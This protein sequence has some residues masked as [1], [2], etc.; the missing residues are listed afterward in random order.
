VRVLYKENE[1]LSEESQMRKR[2]GTRPGSNPTVDRNLLANFTT[3]TIQWANANWHTLDKET[4]VKVLCAFA[5][6][7]IP[8]QVQQETTI[9][10]EEVQS[11]LFERRQ[12]L[13]LN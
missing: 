9:S 3:K 7:Y 8:Q 5:P 13:G 10:V 1:A 11:D 4:K 6:K 12:L 2:K